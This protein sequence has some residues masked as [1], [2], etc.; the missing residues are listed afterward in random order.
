M[1]ENM[2]TQEKG[3]FY[4]SSGEE[5]DMWPLRQGKFGKVCLARQRRALIT[6]ASTWW[7]DATLWQY[8]HHGRPCGGASITAGPTEVRTAPP[9]QRQYDGASITDGPADV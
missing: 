8:E 7:L 3:A 5:E 1:A 6:N 2:T 4:S 9:S